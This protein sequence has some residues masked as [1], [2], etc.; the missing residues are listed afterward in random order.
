MHS[1]NRGDPRSYYDHI[2]AHLH[3]GF[4]ARNA[5]GRRTGAG[6]IRAGAEAPLSPPLLPL[7]LSHTCSLSAPQRP[8]P[9][10]VRHAPRSERAAF[11]AAPGTSSVFNVVSHEREKSQ[12]SKPA[13]PEGLPRVSQGCWKGREGGRSAPRAGHSASPILPPIRHPGGEHAAAAAAPT[14]PLGENPQLLR[15]EGRKQQSEP[16]LTH[17]QVPENSSGAKAPSPVPRGELPACSGRDPGI[18]AHPWAPG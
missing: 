17:P 14:T 7:A 5:L 13:Q 18:F 15:N 10:H 2:P 1:Q 4:P 12:R 9:G 11:A 8:Q 6:K 16:V 3:L